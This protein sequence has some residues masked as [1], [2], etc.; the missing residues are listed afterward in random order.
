VAP[1]LPGVSTYADV[2]FAA[3]FDIK[4]LMKKFLLGLFSMG[5]LVAMSDVAVAQLPGKV[6]ITAQ[7]KKG[8]DKKG[9]FRGEGSISQNSEKQSYTITLQ[10]RTSADLANLTVDYIIFVERQ[11]VGEKKGNEVVQRVKSSLKV[12]NLSRK[13]QTLSTDE[14]TLNSSNVVGNYI[15]LDGGRIKAEDSLQGIWVRV[16][17]DGK[18]IGEYAI[19][20]TMTSRGWDKN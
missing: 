19:P 18:Q 5:L 2:A 13:P 1:K 6:Q 15:Y 8:D 4:R 10:N 7:K 9:A 17:Q 12:E 16:S 11:R 14:V 3:L 20:S